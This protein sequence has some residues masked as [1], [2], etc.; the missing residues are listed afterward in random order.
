MVPKQV[1]QLRMGVNRG[2]MVMKGYSTFFRVLD[3]EQWFPT[4]L[5]PYPTLVFPKF[6]YPS[7][8]FHSYILKMSQQLTWNTLKRPLT[9]SL[10]KPHR[11]SMRL[12]LRSTDLEPYHRIQLLSLPGDIDC[13]RNTYDWS[14]LFAVVLVRLHNHHQKEKRFW[15]FGEGPHRLGS[16]APCGRESGT[17]VLDPNN[18]LWDTRLLANPDQKTKYGV[19]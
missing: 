3:L 9:W 1:L 11:W 18:R 16:R 19:N 4:D 17:S 8:I 5:G 2:V 13:G 15:K 12:T 6:W 10:N 14:V 7:V